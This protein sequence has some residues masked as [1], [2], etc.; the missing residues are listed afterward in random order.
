M[1]LSSFFRY[2]KFREFDDLSNFTLRNEFEV[3]AN[4]L[5]YNTSFQIF[6]TFFL[7]FINEVKDNNEF[8]ILFMLHNNYTECEYKSYHVILPADPEG[9]TGELIIGDL[10]AATDREFIQ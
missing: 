3:N 10:N 1:R 2:I 5:Q 7:D 6:G 8:G 4:K 9:K